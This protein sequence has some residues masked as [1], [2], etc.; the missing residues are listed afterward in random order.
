MQRDRKPYPGK[1]AYNTP[2]RRHRPLFLAAVLL[3]ISLIYSAFFGQ[4]LNDYRERQENLLMISSENLASH[5]ETIIEGYSSFASFVYDTVVSAPPVLEIMRE[6]VHADTQQREQLRRDLFT[7]LEED[8]ELLTSYHYRQLHFHLPN[9]DS[10]L[11]FHTPLTYGD[12]LFAVRRSIYTVNTELQA[13]SGYEEG[14][15]FNGYRFVSPL[16]AGGEHVGSA[17][18][19]LSMA[20]VLLMLQEQFPADRIQFIV[21]AD[22]VSSTVF[23]EFQQNYG[24]HPAL[25]GFMI[26]KEVE[27]T[28]SSPDIMLTEK[29]CGTILKRTA[30]LSP[31]TLSSGESFGEILRYGRRSYSVIFH[32]VLDTAG[33]PS[34]YVIKIQQ[35]SLADENY[36]NLIQILIAVTLIYLLLMA[37]TIVYYLQRNKLVDLAATDVLTGLPNR[38]HFLDL[39]QRADSRANSSESDYS[40]IVADIDHFKKVND[41]FGHPAGD[42][43]LKHVAGILTETL[44]EAG[45]LARWGGEEF[46]ILLLKTRLQK[47]EETAER[48]REAMEHHHFPIAGSLTA[49]FGVAQRHSRSSLTDTI[50]RADQ[51]LYRAKE[52]G[53]NRVETDKTGK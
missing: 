28:V 39:A 43:V 35:S 2:M 40:L 26:D 46:I 13:V 34:A 38:L 47:A 31:E 49:S 16:I 52:L 48:L 29:L 32:S 37:A 27:K 36:R 18:M 33:V 1:G 45:H 41:T 5:I 21:P 22:T 6:A 11:R 3:F 8:Y 50:H 9:G 25:P 7:L 42:Q 15:I 53:R 12:N 23:E 20:T 4:I 44:G 10:F 17:E 14:R 24:S 51:A 30:E 19:S